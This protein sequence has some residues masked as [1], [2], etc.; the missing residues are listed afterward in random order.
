MYKLLIVDD[1]RMIADL[2]YEYLM[3]KLEG[4]VE[5][6]KCYSGRNAVG[7]ME[8]T[9]INILITDITMPGIDGLEL[10]KRAKEINAH[11]KI[12]FL[13]GFNDFSHIQYALRNETVDYILKSENNE[14]ICKSI[15]KA[16]NE[17]E[18]AFQAEQSRISIQQQW[19][20][21]LPVLQ[22][23]SI[24]SMLEGE[25]ISRSVFE[26]IKF[27][28]C[29]NDK[30]LLMLAC[31]DEGYAITKTAFF[32]LKNTVDEYMRQNGKVFSVIN[33]NDIVWIIQA[34]G[35]NIAATKSIIKSKMGTIHDLCLKS[36]KVSMSFVLSEDFVPFEDISITWHG[37]KQTVKN[38]FGLSPG[39]LLI[40]HNNHKGVKS[41]W[42]YIRNILQQ[43]NLCIESL[44]QEKYEKHY[45][46]L[47]SVLRNAPERSRPEKVEI[48]LRIYLSF[49][50]HSNNNGNEID[51][52]D[53]F[54]EEGDWDQHSSF[55]A[56]IAEDFFAKHH[57]SA[58]KHTNEILGNLKHYIH[59]N[60]G[61]DTSLSKLAEVVHF[62]PSYLSR[63][64][65]QVTNISLTE[66]IG[67]L[68]YEKATHLLVNSD[69]KIVQ[70]A[71]EL[72]FETQSYF[73]RFFKKHAGLGPQEFR[74][75]H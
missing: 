31:L 29:L 39:M 13:T 70:I 72:G 42:L 55:L 58:F 2:L 25:A 24:L 27:P 16:I 15:R 32:R 61:G 47:M 9:L 5:L 30:V 48:T 36:F 53:C 23:R 46:E 74:D 54:A 45:A 62:S 7:I 35:A 67:R 75:R 63:L 6:Y 43:I 12:I 18:D 65:K 44:Q 8:N 10:H 60:L 4:E 22:E 50:S 66:Y 21:S 38:L 11:C 69:M 1:E 57:R 28:L 19:E 56:K 64:F 26:E 3:N 41:D 59:A 40:E 33:G 51:F 49:L 37:L 14:V 34:N 52:L 73:S 71:A 17:L 20:L 68:K